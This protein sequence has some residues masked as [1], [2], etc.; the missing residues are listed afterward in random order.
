MPA[1]SRDAIQWHSGDTEHTSKDHRCWDAHCH[2]QTTTACLVRMYH[3]DGAETGAQW[4][5]LQAHDGFVQSTPGDV[6]SPM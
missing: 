5:A 4:A 3:S 1:F 2:L 6:G